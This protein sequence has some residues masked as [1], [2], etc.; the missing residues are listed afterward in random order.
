MKK[1]MNA[2]DQINNDWD[3]VVEDWD[4]FNSSG[5]NVHRDFL[6]L[7]KFI[8]AL[9]PYK[10]D[11]I[12][13]EIGGG[14]GTLARSLTKKGYRLISTD[15][16]KKM[17]QLACKKEIQEPLEIKYQIENAQSLS[18]SNNSFDFV[19]SFMSLMDMQYPDKVFKEIY[20]IL[21]PGGYFQFSILHPCFGSPPYH[22][23]VKNDKG[24]KIALEIGRYNEEGFQE[25]SWMI[26]NNILFKTKHNHITLSNWIMLIISSGLILEYIKEPYADEAIIKVCPHLKHT[27]TVPDNMLI[28]VR[29]PK[30]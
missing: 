3:L 27:V 17:V 30:K 1:S 20:R 26:H 6:N 29:K 15:F 16:S 12:G 9:P 5:K 21:K 13:L 18:F 19:I 14:E 7:P 8:E 11:T 25:L 24:E 22:K 4:L 10:K 2:K 28:R 23:H